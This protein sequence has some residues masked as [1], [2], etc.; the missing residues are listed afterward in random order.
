ME[1]TENPST[2]ELLGTKHHRYREARNPKA[3]IPMTL[4]KK[5]ARVP[6][7]SVID[8]DGALL[9]SRTQQAIG[10]GR[11]LPCRESASFHDPE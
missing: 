11:V 6:V 3:W 1:T 2:G 8:G 10:V 9:G 5:E 7:V 4:F